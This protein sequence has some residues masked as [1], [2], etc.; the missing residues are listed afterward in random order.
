MP[1]IIKIADK[2]D[3]PKIQEYLKNYWSENHIFVKNKKLFIWQHTY[4]DSQKLNFLIAINEK[5]NIC[6]VLGFISNNL[7]DFN[8]C[9]WTAI[10]S[11]QKTICNSKNTG[12]KLFEFFFNKFN[13]I[14][15][16]GTAL[17]PSVVNIYK[18][19]GF[20]IITTK[21]NFI[22][23]V[24]KSNLFKSSQKI[25]KKFVK[26][27]LKINNISI[28]KIGQEL[29]DKTLSMS[30]NN[31]NYKFSYK[32]EKYLLHRYKSHPIYKYSLIKIC[33]NN[34]TKCLMIIKKVTIKNKKILRV[35][36]IIFLD[37][38]INR[39]LYR[40]IL[41]SFIINNNYEYVD[42]VTAGASNNLAAQLGFYERSKNDLIPGNFEPYEKKNVDNIIAYKTIKED[43]YYFFK[44]DSDADRPR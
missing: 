15:I 27:S 3:I 6:G 4:D 32:D 17:T 30:L 18:L 33:L 31:Y 41:A 35:I 12:M 16:S 5:F 43:K 22:P 2:K 20:K 36:D 19:L 14:I 39:L 28:N 38:S 23:G 25:K 13:P 44:G 8:K 7:T 1:D 9:T 26:N 34:F 21:H 29:R 42:F 10:W 11:T 37:L 24:N 40:D